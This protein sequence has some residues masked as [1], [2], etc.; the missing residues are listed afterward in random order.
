[1]I[2]S[3]TYWTQDKRIPMSEWPEWKSK[4]PLG[5]VPVLEVEGKMLTQ[6]A[7]I[8]ECCGWLALMYETCMVKQ[9]AWSSVTLQTAIVG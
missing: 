7:A 2:Y 3:V 4:M 6:M 8:G 5:Q 1:M 9:G